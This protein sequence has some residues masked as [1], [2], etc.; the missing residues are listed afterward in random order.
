[1][2]KQNRRKKAN[3]SAAGMGGDKPVTVSGRL[4]LRRPA[5]VV[6]NHFLPPV[7]GGKGITVSAL[8]N[9]LA[10]TERWPAERMAAAQLRQAGELVSFAQKMSPF[11][12]DRLAGIVAESEGG[13][14]PGAFAAIPLLT[15][16]DVQT[17]RDTLFSTKLPRGHGPAFDVHTTGSS[18]QPVH[19]KS[20]K[21]SSMFNT[22]VTLRGH[23]WFGRDLAG[24]NVTI[25]VISGDQGR[26]KN[27]NWAAGGTGAGFTY[28]NRIPVKFWK[29]MRVIAPS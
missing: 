11:Y 7:K 16:E 2:A 8:A 19:V 28:S 15:R 4:P 24:T 6:A 9:Y 21:Y 5:P 25:K 29:Q 27:K 3:G 13:L 20:T 22:A 23:R 1:M 10:Q 18:G 26:I 14:S 12:K 17:A